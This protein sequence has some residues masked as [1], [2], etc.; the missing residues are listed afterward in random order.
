LNMFVQSY[1]IGQPFSFCQSRDPVCSVS[2]SV[3]PLLTFRSFIIFLCP[4][5]YMMGHYLKF[6][7]TSTVRLVRTHMFAHFT[8]QYNLWLLFNPYPQ[9]S[10]CQWL[11]R[12]CGF[13]STAFTILKSE[14]ILKARGAWVASDGFTTSAKTQGQW[15]NADML[16]LAESELAKF[17]TRTQKWGF[18]EYLSVY[19]GMSMDIIS[20]VMHHSPSQ[21]VYNYMEQ[22]WKMHFY[23]L[24][25][26]FFPVSAR[27]NQRSFYPIPACL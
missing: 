22:I 14:Q 27:S 24:A 7:S 12:I 18:T 16:Q 19:Y 5:G 3:S 4:V 23:D 1:S 11:L 26:N 21:N 17:V 13:S 6:L 2:R 8:A 9:H 10:T 20:A 15:T 25:M